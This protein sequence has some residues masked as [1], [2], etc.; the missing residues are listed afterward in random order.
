[1]KFGIRIL[2]LAPVFT[3]ACS[4]GDSGPSG[5]PGNLAGA[6]GTSFGSGGVG[7]A[8]A[9][10][11]GTGA[12]NAGT[13]ATSSGGAA[14]ATGGVSSVV[15]GGSGGSSPVSSGGASPVG[16]GGGMPGG[17]VPVGTG[18][19]PAGGGGAAGAGAIGGQTFTLSTT[20]F[21]VPPG[22]EM[23]MAQNFK[24]PVGKDVALVQSHTVMTKGSH[25][26][27]VFH[28]VLFNAD[29]NGTGITDGTEFH[30]YLTLAQSPD[31]VDTYPSGVGQVLPS[32]EGLRIDMHYI[33]TGTDPL[34]AKVDVTF[35]YIDPT[36][37]Q[38]PAS[39]IFLDNTGLRINPNAMGQK[40][41]ADYTLPYPITLLS[42]VS[43]M[44]SRGV[45]FTANAGSNMI[46]DGIA[47]EDPKPQVF[48]PP[49]PISGGIHW[50]CTYD[51]TSSNTITFGEHA[52]TNEMCIL[53]ALFYATASTSPQGQAL[54][55]PTCDSF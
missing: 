49:M 22:G 37:L 55:T 11:T 42:A 39:M 47:W 50:E 16:N 44:H 1:M 19:V 6:G 18:G 9:P 40:V 23:Y 28:S 51:N 15:G 20:P 54:C 46:Y 38:H 52:Q 8:T 43:H 45:H 33:N 29:S 53:T 30:P 10:I 17:G 13:G 14:N 35:T 32:T 4:G 5:A 3:L 26:M 41:G 27:F 2:A 7:G 21:D 24:N 25:H 31:S 12:T 34:S 36:T 48:S